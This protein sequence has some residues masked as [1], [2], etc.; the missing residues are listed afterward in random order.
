MSKSYCLQ[1]IISA[2]NGPLMAEIL[3]DE[4]SEK[5]LKMREGKKNIFKKRS[6]SY[7]KKE[8]ENLELAITKIMR[9]TTEESHANYQCVLDK[10]HLT[11]MDPLYNG[12]CPPVLFGKHKEEATPPAAPESVSESLI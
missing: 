2:S 12:P 5:I 8:I 6:K 10:I 9:Q 1:K 11:G 4:C 7:Y 3:A